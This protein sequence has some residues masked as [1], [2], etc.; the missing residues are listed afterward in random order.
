M[1]ALIGVV[2]FSICVLFP[3][4]DRISK[5]GKIPCI[6]IEVRR[7]DNML[8]LAK[9][10]YFRDTLSD[11]DVWKQVTYR[12]ATIMVRV[13]TADSIA[14]A[15]REHGKLIRDVGWRGIDYY[16]TRGRKVLKVSLWLLGLACLPL[17]APLTAATWRFG[18]RK[19][20]ARNNQCVNCGY[21][22]RGLI[23]SRCP[24]CG[25]QIAP[26]RPF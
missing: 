1:L 4:V 7:L 6:D 24:E 12:D 10:R 14:Q 11:S 2:G 17:C 25:G 20:R 18:R 26:G 9:R 5:V 23:S 3:R 16:T 13:A 15:L 19:N 8:I 21:S 22:L